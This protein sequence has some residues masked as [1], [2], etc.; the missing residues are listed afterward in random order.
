MK[1]AVLIGLAAVFAVSMTVAIAPAGA[2][3]SQSDDGTYAKVET[4]T[5]E[6]TKKI[7]DGLRKLYKD[8]EAGTRQVTKK[9]G[10]GLR[11]A[12]REVTKK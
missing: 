11:T 12:W 5:R 8:V 6:V 1:R 3:A 2:S 4:G 9:I 7:G 10:D